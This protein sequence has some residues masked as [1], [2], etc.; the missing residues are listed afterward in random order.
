MDIKKRFFGSFLYNFSIRKK[1]F[2]SSMILTM[3]LALTYY[4]LSQQY[5]MNLTMQGQSEFMLNSFEQTGKHTNNYFEDIENNANA[6][7]H[8][9]RLLTLLNK[10]F[11]EQNLFEIN[12]FV[13][14]LDH[15]INTYIWEQ[16]YIDQIVIL[17]TNDLAYV[18][19]LSTAGKYMGNGFSFSAFTEQ[20]DLLAPEYRQALPFFYQMD[21]AN[22][23]SN[24]AELSLNESLTNKLV[25][26]KSLASNMDEMMGLMIITFK[27]EVI[28][29]KV[30]A[31]ALKVGNVYVVSNQTA[32]WASSNQT[33]PI[34]SLP[35]APPLD[36]AYTV[37]SASGTKLV[38]TEFTLHPYDFKLISEIPLSYYSTQTKVPFYIYLYALL[39]FLFVLIVSYVF[40]N[41]ISKPL[42]DLSLRL[43]ENASGLP[44]PFNQNPSIS[45]L[46]IRLRTKIVTYFTV[47]VFVPSIAFVLILTYIYY[48]DYQNKV[49]QFTTSTIHQVK[50][51]IDNNLTSYAGITKQWIHGD[52]L[53]TI[54]NATL[55]QP[56]T[57]IHYDTIDSQFIHLKMA[58]KEFVSLGL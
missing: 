29:D 17:G 39:A 6:M 45:F 32:I 35:S 8:S 36:N 55:E 38:Y 48:S 20:T 19:T 11:Q 14:A 27:P 21:P 26:V 43:A 37:S 18:Y 23:G 44:L 40:S 53:Q 34:P 50:S 10:P 49:T 25:L 51:N 15:E 3:I 9:D 47:T 57:T 41:R 4:I 12:Q 42:H 46:N 2:I 13:Q 22:F 16:D 7:S 5:V 24:S 1:L 52:T 28:A 56:F 31:E 58:K 54:L 33:N 30:D